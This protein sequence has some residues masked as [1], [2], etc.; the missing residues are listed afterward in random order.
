MALLPRLV[1]VHYRV[2]RVACKAETKELGASTHRRGGKWGGESGIP[3][4]RRLNPWV[5]PLFALWRRHIF[6]GGSPL[7]YRLRWRVSLPCSGW[8]R[9]G[10]H[11]SSHQK[12][13]RSIAGRC[14]ARKGAMLQDC[15][16]SFLD[17]PCGISQNTWTRRTCPRRDLAG[18]KASELLEG[19][20]V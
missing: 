19:G 4:K 1:F 12:A 15:F 8:E 6:R 17:T 10:P 13:R 5:E 3:E 9:V 16:W 20:P 7:E 11:R 2:H 14:S 18:G